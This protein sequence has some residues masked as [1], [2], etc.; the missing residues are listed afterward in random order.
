M[1]ER[2]PIRRYGGNT[3]KATQCKRQS[4]IPFFSILRF[5][6]RRS[7]AR[8]VSITEQRWLWLN[9]ATG[10][11]TRDA[12]TAAIARLVRSERVPTTAFLRSRVGQPPPYQPARSC[13]IGSDG[14]EE[15]GAKKETGHVRVETRRVMLPL[16]VYQRR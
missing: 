4:S 6:R 16:P 12:S 13:T 10:R 11:W 15:N 9:T 14:R 7:I 2:R 3:H 5:S 1:A 8:Q